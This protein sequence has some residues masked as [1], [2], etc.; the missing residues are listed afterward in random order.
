MGTHTKK[1]TKTQEDV[2]RREERL[3]HLEDKVQNEIVVRLQVL[4]DPQ[5]KCKS[6]SRL[7]LYPFFAAPGVLPGPWERVGETPTEKDGENGPAVVKRRKSWEC[8]R[9]LQSAKT[10][11]CVQGLATG[12]I[13]AERVQKKPNS[14]WVF[15]LGAEIFSV[16][17]KISCPETK[18][19]A[20]GPSRN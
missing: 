5:Q 9:G 14:K 20:G 16:N 15:F 17:Q 19:G 8:A 7:E 4:S 3:Q 18:N 10:G 13:P 1:V 12:S 2:D 6:R 11:R